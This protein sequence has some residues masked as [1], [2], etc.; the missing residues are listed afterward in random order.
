M[1]CKLAYFK[2]NDYVARS[3]SIHVT[4]QSKNTKNTIYHFS[5]KSMKLIQ[6]NT[7]NYRPGFAVQTQNKHKCG[8]RNWDWWTSFD[9]IKSFVCGHLCSMTKRSVKCLVS[10][11]FCFFFEKPH[12]SKHNRTDYNT[13]SC[14]C[15]YIYMFFVFGLHSYTRLNA[16]ILFTWS[17]ETQ[18]WSATETWRIWA[19]D[20]L[21]GAHLL[22]E[23]LFFSCTQDGSALCPRAIM[24]VNWSSLS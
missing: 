12:Q 2:S 4:A 3:I 10:V 6:Q 15:T 20:P 23:R 22:S 18:T 1:N 14:E 11:F 9:L 19:F 13:Q 17:R 7:I 8:K 24:T 5:H 16:F 21:T